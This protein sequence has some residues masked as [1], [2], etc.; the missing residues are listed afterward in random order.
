[1]KVFRTTALL[2]AL[3]AVCQAD[4]AP[5]QNQA[6]DFRMKPDNMAEQPSPSNMIVP[7]EVPKRAL[8]MNLRV[9]LGDKIERVRAAYNITANPTPTVNEQLMLVAP[10]HGM[11]FFFK[12]KEQ[13]LC[14]IR[15]DAPFLGSINGVRIADTFENVV[16]T[17]GKPS[18][19]PWDFGDNKAYRFRVGSTW[20]RCDFNKEQKVA[21]IFLFPPAD[22]AP[23]LTS[24]VGGN[25]HRHDQPAE[26]STDNNTFATVTDFINR[27]AQLSGQRV[28]VTGV[29]T[30]A[31]VGMRS[32]GDWYMLDGKIKCHFRLGSHCTEGSS[33]ET[34]RT[35]SI[36]GTV[37]G[38]HL[39]TP[40][41]VNCDCPGF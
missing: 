23:S 21:T 41:L 26:Q 37:S 11:M 24:D 8:T 17:L 18:G 32:E 5:A 29:V 13:T 14:N 3:T 35:V 19:D 15:A 31:V 16:A 36:T 39:G 9:A 28:R 27:R 2:V 1:M 22:N 34:R 10:A 7:A 30:E 33:R 12:E 20:L 6:Q 40:K 4:D 25:N 38:D